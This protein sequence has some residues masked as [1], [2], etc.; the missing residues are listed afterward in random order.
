MY[1]EFFVMP[2]IRSSPDAGDDFRVPLQSP[3]TNDKGLPD[4]EPERAA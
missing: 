3:L 2:G 4:R 1:R